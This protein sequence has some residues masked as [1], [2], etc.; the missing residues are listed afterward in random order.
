M[1]LK[2]DDQLMDIYFRNQVIKEILA[3]E[4]VERRKSHLKRRE[5]FKDQTAKWVIDR[6]KKENLHEDTIKMMANRCAN[7]SILKKIIE[8]L[9]RTYKGGVVRYTDEE[10]TTSIVNEMARLL[11]LDQ[12][13]KKADKYLELHKNSMAYI[14]PEKCDEEN[15]MKPKIRILAPWQYDVIEDNVDRERPRVLILSQY[16]EQNDFNV[17]STDN[18]DNVIADAPDDSQMYYDDGRQFVWWSDKYHFTTNSGGEIIAALSP[19][20]NLNPIQELPFVNY[21]DDQDGEF[22]AQG[23]DDLVEGS[24]L[25]NL[26]MTDMFSIANAQGYGLPVITGSNLKSNLNWGPNRALLMNYDKEND[27]KPEVDIISANPPLD[28]WMRIIEQYV[29]LLLSSNKLSPSSIATKLEGST[30]PSGIAMLVEMSEATDDIQD[31]QTMFKNGER[32]TFEILVKWQNL[33]LD[34]GVLDDDFAVLG[35]LPEDLAVN[36]KFNDIKPVTTEKEKLEVIKFRKE[37]GLNE[38]IELLMMDNPDLTYDEAVEKLKRIKQEKLENFSGFTMESED[39]QDT[40][41]NED[42]V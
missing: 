12:Q 13:Q 6:L 41:D 9:A 23:G 21:A 14:Y 17:D 33:L 32:E 3:N 1:Q 15:K 16:T 5:I 37:L 24:I 39:K 28:M 34:L 27:A 42:D 31:K 18:V 8:K 30:F 2:Y 29:A 25:I 11:Q 4:N 36:V 26:L 35:K 22:W 38:E 40:Q 20:G 7:I 10:T 19:E